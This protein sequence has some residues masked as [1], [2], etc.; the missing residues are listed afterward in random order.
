MVYTDFV[1]CLVLILGAALICIIG[2]G[3]VS[4]WGALRE[5]VAALPDTA[6]HFNLVRPARRPILL[7]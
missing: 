4:G 7:V 2:L 3:E 5:M 1:S 6:Q